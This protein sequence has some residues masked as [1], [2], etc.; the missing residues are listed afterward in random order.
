[1]LRAFTFTNLALTLSLAALPA[2]ASS[3]TT[4]FAGTNGFSGNMFSATISKSLTITSLDVDVT[5]GAATI[6]VYQK[7]GTYVGFETTPA[8]WTLESSTTTTGLGEGLSALV[9]VTPFSLSAGNTYSLYITISAPTSAT[10]FYSDGNS[11]YS[12][13]DL[14][15][16]LGEGIGGLFG[17][18]GVFPSRTWNGT[19]NYSLISATAGVPEPATLRL[20]A[21]FAV[22]ASSLY[23]YRSLFSHYFKLR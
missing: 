1:M 12:N 10:M 13:S 18:S 17:A 9:T 20:L 19:I 6:Q 15:L 3:I 4:T 22:S 11:A 5:T 14:S 16:S 2:V 23:L 8:A 21:L 7:I